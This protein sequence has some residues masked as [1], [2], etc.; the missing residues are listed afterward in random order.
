MLADGLEVGRPAE[1]P[2]T[3]VDENAGMKEDRQAERVRALVHGV[4]A[5][6]VGV[7]PGRDELQ[8]PDA[9]PRDRLVEIVG[10][11]RMQ[12]VHDREADQPVLVAADEVGEAP[13][14]VAERL[15]VLQPV[16]VGQE[17][18]EQHA[19]VDL[20]LVQAPEHVARI[21][22]AREMKMSVDQHAGRSD[23]VGLVG[24]AGRWLR[25]KDG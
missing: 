9:A 2:G 19:D 11:L 16:R 15:A 3:P 22:P 23:V 12:R 14:A 8:P 20:G 18:R 10:R 24:S 21:F 6:V 4:S 5:V 13:V 17:R 1:P 25:R 7:P